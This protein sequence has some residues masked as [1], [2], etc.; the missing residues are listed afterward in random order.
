MEKD[1]RK[2]LSYYPNSYSSI[3]NFMASDGEHIYNLWGFSRV[4][5]IW[6]NNLASKCIEN[7]ILHIK[8]IGPN[9]AACIIKHMLDVVSSL[10]QTIELGTVDAPRTKSENC[11]I[12]GWLV[13]ICIVDEHIHS[14]EYNRPWR[15]F[16]RF[17]TKTTCKIR[18]QMPRNGNQ[19][20]SQCVRYRAEPQLSYDIVSQRKHH[21]LDIPCFFA[22]SY[23]FIHI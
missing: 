20:L 12:V 1:L 4:V 23:H 19:Q 16:W 13:I 21:G 9:P 8:K 22:S 7:M 5:Y 6:C 17:P 11:A 3:L 2:P 18:F 14:I 10:E 15:H